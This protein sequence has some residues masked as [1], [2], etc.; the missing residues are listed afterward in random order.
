MASA[1]NPSV[2]ATLSATV[3]TVLSTSITFTGCSTATIGGGISLGDS[4]FGDGANI[5]GDGAASFTA[6]LSRVTPLLEL[7]NSAALGNVPKF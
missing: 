7:S 1:V 4:W 3:S 5:T 6:N 2:F